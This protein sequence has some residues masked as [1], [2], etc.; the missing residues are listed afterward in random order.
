MNRLVCLVCIFSLTNVSAQGYTL[1]PRGAQEVSTPG[2]MD[3]ALRNVGVA[4]MAASMTRCLRPRKLE[5]I[6]VYTFLI[7]ATIFLVRE[8]FIKSNFDKKSKKIHEVEQ[9]STVGEGMRQEEALRMAA[10]QSYAAAKASEKKAKNAKYFRTFL[11]LVAGMFGSWPLMVCA[12][13]VNPSGYLAC[14]GAHN[15]TGEGKCKVQEK[16]CG[17]GAGVAGCSDNTEAA[18][19]AADCSSST[20]RVYYETCKAK[21]VV[22][23]NAW[24]CG[25]GDNECA[26]KA[27][28]AAKSSGCFEKAQ[29]ELESCV[30]RVK[31][32]AEG[33]E[34]VFDGVDYGGYGN[35]VRD[36]AAALP[37]GAGD[38]PAVLEGNLEEARSQAAE[39]TE[40]YESARKEAD[41]DKSAYEAALSRL[42]D[43]HDDS[44]SGPS[45]SQGFDDSE[46]TR[47][48]ELREK[49]ETS[50]AR[51]DGLEAEAAAATSAA[52]QLAAAAGAAGDGDLAPK[53]AAPERTD[54]SPGSDDIHRCPQITEGSNTVLPDSVQEAQNLGGYFGQDDKGDLDELKAQLEGGTFMG[55]AQGGR[56]HESIPIHED[57][58]I[59]YKDKESGAN[60]V[61]TGDKLGNF[62]DRSKFE[63]VDVFFSGDKANKS[64][65]GEY[66]DGGGDPRSVPQVGSVGCRLIDMGQYNDWRRGLNR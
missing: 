3:D 58:Q 9:W 35:C 27:A 6:P 53:A 39:L 11:Y 60:F 19:A 36:K 61:A 21:A 55:G 66:I 57:D 4:L 15:S 49:W 22:S 30:A 23:A 7:G 37:D 52:E 24:E 48:K 5:K 26:A 29:K 10:R 31:G 17:D 38:P 12:K 54:C 32:I 46:A 2:M 14:V 28:A 44:F 1:T 50:K 25:D 56:I 41:D 34:C 45:G 33:S 51:A 42:E 20:D 64:C 18:V 62:T 65:P 16:E 13:G 40:A 47:V 59:I 63:V 8:V 43:N